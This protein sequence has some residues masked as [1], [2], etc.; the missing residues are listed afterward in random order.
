MT[1]NEQ[2]NRVEA[3]GASETAEAAAHV[4]DDLEA[5]RTKAAER[6]TFHELL[7]RTR[8][9]F[10]NY[11]KRAHRDLQEERRYALRSFALEL[12][13][14]LDNLER[15]LAAVKEAS[16]LSKGV[17]IVQNQLVETLKR[18][19]I[20]RIEPKHVPF[21]PHRHEAV[22][23]QPAPQQPANTVLQTLEPGY[24]YHDRVLR[25]AKVIVSK[26]E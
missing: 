23:Q 6:D 10:D 19:G 2:A 8:A 17:A 26:T 13:P 16:A 24:L 12:L 22:M 21:D 25:P 4:L 20:T 5:L 9:D 14:A 1:D 18:H 11:Q 7:L 15:A 3:E